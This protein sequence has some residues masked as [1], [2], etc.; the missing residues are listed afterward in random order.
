MKKLITS[1]VLIFLFSLSSVKIYAIAEDIDELKLTTENT[2]IV[3]A[4][5]M[6]SSIGKELVPKGVILG[7]ND[8]EEMT[9]TYTIFV[10]YGVQVD[11]SVNNIKIDNQ[12]VSSDINDLFNFD[13]QVNISRNRHLQLEIFDETEAGYFMDITVVLT[14][15]NPTESQFREISGQQL[16]FEIT[17]QSVDETAA[18][19]M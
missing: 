3:I 9:F 17:F 16:S 19:T 14:M 11:Y 2:Q 13:F 1:L 8:V 18:N 4:Q 10:Q 7:V 12:N 5:T 6:N 15:N